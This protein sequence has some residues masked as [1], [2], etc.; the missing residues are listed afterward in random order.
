MLSKKKFSVGVI[1]AGI[2]GVCISL[3]LIKKGFKVTLLDRSEP[4]NSA[5]Y[6]NAGHFSPYASVPINR[7]DILVDVPA[8]LLSSNGPL[9]L[10]W[11][12]VP[13]M[14]PWIIK[15]IKNCTNKKM[16]HT[17]KYM[18]QILDLALPAYDE[19]FEEIDI[20]NLVEK[21]GI[22]YFWNNQN[23]KSRELEINLRKELGV[24]QKLL[25]KHEIHDLEPN[26]RQVY[27]A[28]VFYPSARHAR[29]P[30]KILEKLFELFIQKGGIFEKQNVE[31]IKYENEKPQIKTN[32]KIFSFD[33][34]V[35]AC[36]A[37]SKQLTDQMNEKIPLD[38]ER[39]YHVHFKGYEHLLQRPVVF[40]NRGFGITPME[41]GL[42]V[43]GTVEFGGLKNPLNKR[44]IK[45]LVRNAKYLFPDLPEHEDEW[46][47]FR[48][49]LPD[50]LPVIGPSKKYKNILYAFGHHHLGWT[51][52]AITGKIISKIINEENTNLDLNPY[53]STRF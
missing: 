46:L 13:K 22:M 51:L 12:Y 36:G 38:T 29:N 33:K 49:T 19:L 11:N 25:N 47:G 28:G 1:G 32:K 34:A 43:V 26:I 4:G 14:I 45:N 17:A 53:I 16:K 52:G 31:E 3:C 50:Y 41:Q 48:P 15:F 37:F 10:K 35:I 7:P 42:R 24:E 30:K 6:G 27:D 44:R 8:M 39:G 40:Q 21:K 5:S 18:H 9:A 20:S 23:L 2:Q